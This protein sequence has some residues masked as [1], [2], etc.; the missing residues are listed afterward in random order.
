MTQPLH[1]SQL[2]KPGKHKYRIQTKAHAHPH[3]PWNEINKPINY[4]WSKE[5]FPQQLKESIFVPVYEEDDKIVIIVEG[6]HCC[7]L[8]IKSYPLSFSQGYAHM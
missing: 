7:Q 1:T 6:Y 5:E 8:C 2:L 4:I 3:T